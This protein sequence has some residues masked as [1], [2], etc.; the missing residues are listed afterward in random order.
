METKLKL[1]NSWECKLQ[2]MNQVEKTGILIFWD[3]VS[4]HFSLAVFVKIFNFDLELEGAQVRCYCLFLHG[5]KQADICLACLFEYISG[6]KIQV[7]TEIIKKNWAYGS[8]KLFFLWHCMR[9]QKKKKQQLYKEIK[10]KDRRNR[11]HCHLH[12]H[13]YHVLFIHSVSIDQW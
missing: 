5:I 9:V 3:F 12:E 11:W 2:L 13:T 10:F 7:I 4:V 8:F 1:I 6:T